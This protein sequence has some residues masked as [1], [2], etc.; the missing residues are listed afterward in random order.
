MRISIH[1]YCCGDEGLRFVLRQAGGR[2]VTF[3]TT[4]VE[5]RGWSL[6]QSLFDEY[7]ME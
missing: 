7:A 1:R 4:P 2:H 3:R 5:P 6:A